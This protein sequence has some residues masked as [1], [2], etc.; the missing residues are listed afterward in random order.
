MMELLRL[1]AADQDELPQCPPE[2]EAC[3][4]ALVAK[5]RVH[6]CVARPHDDS[7]EHGCSCGVDWA[8]VT[9]PTTDEE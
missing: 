6:H 8:E 1:L 5:E 9:E 4:A 7:V 3:N 2:D